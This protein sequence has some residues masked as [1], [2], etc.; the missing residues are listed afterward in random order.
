VRSE[1][2][3]KGK[4]TRRGLALVLVVGLAGPASAEP[5]SVGFGSAPLPTPDG[6]GLA[7]YGG[8]RQ[9]RAEGTLDVPDA[10]AVVLD[11]GGLR[12]ALVAIDILISRPALRDRLLEEA[13]RLAIDSVVFVATHTHSGPGGYIEGWAAARVTGA[14]FEAEAP[15]R[16]ADAAVRALRAAVDDLGR[17]RVGSAL[18]RAELAENRREEDGPGEVSLPVI[19]VET[20]NGVQRA[21]FAYAAHPIV[22]SPKSRAYSAD[23]PGA[24]RRWLA[25]RGWESTF[26]PGP[27]GDQ[28]PV[29]ALGPLWPKT[30]E[31]QR[32]QAEEIGERLGEAVLS[33]LSKIE[34]RG[35]VRFD[36]VE[37]WVDAPQSRLRRGCLVW[38]LS[39]ISRGPLRSFLSPRVPFHAVR[40]GDAV[41][42]AVP[43]EPTTRVGDRLRASVPEGSVPLVVS[44]ANDWMGYVVEREQYGR[45]G[46]EA[47]LSF[48]GDGLADWL[49]TEA[50]ETVR[51]L[52]ARRTSPRATRTPEPGRT[53]ISGSTR[54]TSRSTFRRS[55]SRPRLPAC[56][57][58]ASVSS[59]S[60]SPTRSA[61]SR[62]RTRSPTRRARS[63]RPTP[64]RAPATASARR[65][66]TGSGA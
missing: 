39:P 52:D 3:S 7:G 65:T 58:W 56:A 41:L 35:S 19:R 59:R 63:V 4:T 40:I 38:W 25:S 42:L 12:V 22:L 16:L 54:P 28:R 26:V 51:L 55:G 32:A 33:T 6:A 8:L 24:A 14:G 23:Y 53:K 46:Y 10:R 57:L 11:Q 15:D 64:S 18:G 44:H 34:P 30:V 37:R 62:W 27:L 13:E 1:H 9:R 20:G 36:A 21:L 50:A 29:S 2:G 60:P 45:G 5:L 31:E 47:C 61:C 17:A 66:P 49:V 48:F 43:A